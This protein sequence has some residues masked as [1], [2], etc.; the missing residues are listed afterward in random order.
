M[1]TVLILLA[2]DAMLV[3]PALLAPVSLNE[4][5][6]WIESASWRGYKCRVCGATL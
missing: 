5:E 4:D 1:E 2:S 3:G 6:E